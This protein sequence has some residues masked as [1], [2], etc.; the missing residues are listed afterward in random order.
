MQRTM[1][2]GKL[3]RGCISPK[4]DLHYEGFCAIDQNFLDAAA[5]LEYEA[6]DLYN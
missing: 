3:H 4:A 6:I 1:L 2:R 5:I